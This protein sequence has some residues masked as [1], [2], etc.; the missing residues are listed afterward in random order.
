MKK[1]K[2][3]ESHKPDRVQVTLSF[4]HHALNEREPKEWALFLRALA[5]TEPFE[6]VHDAE[7]NC[8]QAQHINNV[9]RKAMDNYGIATAPKITHRTDDK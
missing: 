1:P 2:K 4:S 9:T 7:E 8:C 5:G 6:I 3:P